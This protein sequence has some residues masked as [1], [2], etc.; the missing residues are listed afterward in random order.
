MDVSAAIEQ[1]RY[2]PLDA[3]ETLSRLTVNNMPDPVRCTKVVGD[4]IMEATKSVKGTTGRVAAC[5]E[6]ASTLLSKGYAEE[7]IKLEQLWDEITKG[8]GLLTLCG[9]L[10]SAFPSHEADPIFQRICAEHSKIYS[11]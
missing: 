9:Y 4:L 6:T 1:G 7:A 8:Y 11:R 10:S 3:A 2:I 5:G